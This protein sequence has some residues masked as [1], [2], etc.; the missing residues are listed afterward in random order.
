M[1]RVILIAVAL[2]AAIYSV[3]ASDITIPPAELGPRVLLLTSDSS[4]ASASDYAFT[5]PAEA[6]RAINKAGA[7]SSDEVILYVAPGVYWL[8]DP[9]DPAVRVNPVDNRKTPY[10]AEIVCDTLNIVGL[11]DD[12]ADVV[13][14]VNR[15]QTQGA[16]GNY[17]MLHFKGSALYTS[18]VTWGNYCNVDLVYPRDPSLNRPRRRDAI[19]QAQ[20][21]KCEGTS[22][23]YAYNCRFISRLNLCPLTGARRS[24]YNKCYFECTDD[25]L[26][27]SAVYLDCSFTFFSSKPFYSTASTG[28]VFLNCDIDIRTSGTQYF[29]KAPGAVTVIDSRFTSASPVDLRWTRDSSPKRCYQSNVTLNGRPITIDQS[30]PE[31]SVMLDGTPLMDAYKVTVPHSNTVIYNTANL[32]KGDDGW[33]PM[34]VAPAISAI[35]E[36]SGRQLLD[37]PVTLSLPRVKNSLAPAGD[38]LTLTPSPRRW[39]DYDGTLPTGTTMAWQAPSIITVTPQGET[40]LIE[41]SNSYPREA[42]ATI[43]V[44]TSYGLAGATALTVQPLLKDA[45]SFASAPSISLNKSTLSLDYSL[46]HAGA[47]DES[48]IV[49]YRS[50]RPDLS[51]SIAVRHGHGVAARQYP[52]SAADKGCYIS[53]TVTPRLDDTHPGT[54]CA[55]VTF[56]K[57]ISS[58]AI[59][60]NP[61]SR[62]KEFF[63]S[64]A[65]IPIRTNP[66]S[67]RGVW[68]FD[69]YKPADTSEHHWKADGSTGW[70]YGKGVDAATGTGIVQASRG[71]RMFYSPMRTSARGM[72]VELVAEPA[73]GPGQG[74]GSA[75]GQYMDICVAFDPESMTGYGLR[76]ERTPD[77]DK[78]VTFTLVSYRDGQVT[79]LTTPVASSCFRTP[80]TISV[81]M[82]D[83]LL[84]A[85]ASTAAPAAASAD[86]RILPAVNLSA[87]VDKEVTSSKSRLFSGS[88]LPGTSMMIQHTG[89][90]G[91][92]ATLLRDLRLT[93]Q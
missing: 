72:K 34:G 45:P 48:Y 46:T 20:L 73:K 32:L 90:T 55:P 59:S 61:L 62:E 27:G 13:F 79:P 71:A 33:D 93:W 52:L 4:E 78:A 35:E 74:F 57:T 86:S 15:G 9:D 42:D 5:D 26:T 67:R 89:S 3:S 69:T 68:S 47:Q 81:E 17:T 6:I 75:T 58:L 53:A 85:A 38:T 44:S 66:V 29:T 56:G 16:I 77:Y 65:E 19:V 10:A 11:A 14:A 84:T 87:M 18:G 43:N 23:L 28:A 91:A 1:K 12:P 40:A 2:I 83:G 22:R 24:L 50:T 37:L 51:D 49:W 64:F 76:I 36:L 7:T 54:T 21:G 82:R 80:C 70:Y 8:D 31:L 88:T 30:R 63:T 25:A 92:S 60:L 39:G 41:T